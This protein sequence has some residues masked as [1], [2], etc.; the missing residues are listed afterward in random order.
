MFVLVLSQTSPQFFRT[1]PLI[2]T[3]LFA[4]L[5]DVTA[6]HPISQQFQ[7]IQISSRNPYVCS[8]LISI[9]LS[10]PSDRLRLRCVR[11]ISPFADVP[12]HPASMKPVSGAAHLYC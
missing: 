6:V 2:V 9:V 12:A 8:S 1:T 10:P 11:N 4:C 5:R 7:L 3:A